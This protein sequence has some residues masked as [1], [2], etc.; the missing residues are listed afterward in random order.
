MDGL[1]WT[2]RYNHCTIIVCLCVSLSL[3]VSLG[4]RGW[5]RRSQFV[6][7]TKSE[8]HGRVRSSFVWKG[9]ERDSLS[10]AASWPCAMCCNHQRQR[11]H[12]P[13]HHTEKGSWHDHW[14][15]WAWNLPCRSLG[16]LQ[17]HGPGQATCSGFSVAPSP[18]AK[19]SQGTEVS[20]NGL[21]AFTV[22]L[23]DAPS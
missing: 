22:T 6:P 17:R 20:E 18:A 12:H 4:A 8:G 9:K 23:R 5:Q 16:G 19:L 21:R 14:P 1:L 7:P 3:C 2:T 11:G 10:A 15:R 13:I